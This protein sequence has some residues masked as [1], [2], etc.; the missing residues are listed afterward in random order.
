MSFMKGQA[1]AEYLFTYGWALVIL[2]AVI[3][4]IMATGVFNPAYFISEECSIQPDIA[5]TGYQL[6]RDNGDTHLQM[7]IE[8]RLG[9]KVRISEVKFIK[10]EEEQDASCR[11]GAEIE[12]GGECI[13]DTDL[14]FG[15]DYEP[16]ADSTERMLLQL[17]Y[18]TCAREVNPDCDVNDD[19]KHVVTG[20]LV[21]RVSQS[22]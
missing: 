1:A 11:G 14:N 3:V 21:A 4:A 16:A 20:R 12:Q 22:E 15:G 6:Y 19:Y 18:Y 10:G 5:C 7:R 8:N 13:V 17:T 2:V 9:Y